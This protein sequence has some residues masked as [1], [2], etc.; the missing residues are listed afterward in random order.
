MQLGGDFWEIAGN[1]TLKLHYF[2]LATNVAL[3]SMTRVSSKIACVNTL[4]LH[5]CR[6]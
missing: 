2:P 6:R 3:E 4:L 1:I 5:C